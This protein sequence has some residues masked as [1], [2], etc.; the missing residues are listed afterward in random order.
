MINGYKIAALCVSKVHERYIGDF[1]REFNTALSPEGWRVLVYTVN[2]DLYRKTRSDKG[3]A[4]IF[5]LIDYERTEAVVV[6]PASIYDDAVKE[7]IVTKAREHGVRIIMV[8]NYS[9]EGC[10]NMRFDYRS[11]FSQ[12]VRHLSMFTESGISA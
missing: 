6:F 3:E 8:D 7:G 2:S 1:I 10:I 5:D 12:I 9:H 4:Y 11:G